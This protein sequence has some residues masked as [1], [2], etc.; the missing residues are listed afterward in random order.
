MFQEFRR[1]LFLDAVASLELAIW[2]SKFVPIVEIFSK[3]EGFYKV[4]TNKDLETNRELVTNKDWY[5]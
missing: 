1:T 5:F 2:V 3:Y 4:E